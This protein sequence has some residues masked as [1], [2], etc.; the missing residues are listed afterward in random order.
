[1]AF[2][3]AML[4][5][6]SRKRSTPNFPMQGSSARCRSL[7]GADAFRCVRTFALKLHI[8]HANF[9]DPQLSPV[10]EV[11]MRKEAKRVTLELVPYRQAGQDGSHQH[12]GGAIGAV[13]AFERNSQARM[14]DGAAE[15]ALGTRLHE[16]ARH[17]LHQ[18]RA[19][20]VG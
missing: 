18:L 5:K 20:A 15:N 17:H 2:R 8:D 12:F 4:R 19:V 16:G 13:V 6:T 9:A 14:G 3:T 11:G 10:P 1:M 7:Y